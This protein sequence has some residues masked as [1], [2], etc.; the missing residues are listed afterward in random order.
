[1][2]S[3]AVIIVLAGGLLAACSQTVTA[4]T[5]TEVP[6]RWQTLGKYNVVSV[7]LLVGFN[8]ENHG[9]AIGEDGQNVYTLDAGQ[10]WPQA[11]N[12]SMGLYGLEI[13]DDQTAFACGTG[14]N[15]RLTADGGMTWQAGGNF[16]G[17]FPAHCR[18][19]SFADAQ[20][21]WA[22]TPTLLGS[23]T[24]GA[25]SWATL[26]LPA[27]ADSLASISLIAPGQGF[28][29]DVSGRVYATSDNAATWTEAGQLPM[30]DLTIG[31]LSYPLAAMRFQDA[32]HG[33]VVIAAIVDGAGQV[34]AFQTTDGGAS[35]TQETVPATYGAPFLS[36]NGRYL[37]LLTPPYT[38]T[39]IKYNGE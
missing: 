8:D 6:E 16:G 34:V 37:T 21:G 11:D 22:A 1:M 27:G 3:M 30:G 33:M 5:P 25:A 13:V 19:M 12:Q 23:T 2:Q 7:N 26:S 9:I 10:T 38:V 4:P 20:S 18:F 29:L 35:W 36:R 31:S 28:L 32:V 39:V 17:G 15:V 14:M 24:D